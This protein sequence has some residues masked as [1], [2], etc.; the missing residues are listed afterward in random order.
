VRDNGGSGQG[1]GGACNT[2]HACRMHSKPTTD[3]RIGGTNGQ[4]PLKDARGIGPLS[5]KETRDVSRRAKRG[6]GSDGMM[7]ADE[8]GTQGG[9]RATARGH[10]APHVPAQAH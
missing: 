9:R 2:C 4:E 10:A 3:E 6:R 7:D 8:G 1:A 5:P